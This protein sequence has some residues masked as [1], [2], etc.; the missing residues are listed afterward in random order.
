[1]G[2]GGLPWELHGLPWA[3]MGEMLFLRVITGGGRSSGSGIRLLV[4][5]QAV[6]GGKS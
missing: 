2:R 4:S 6:C 1:M 5:L 3:A